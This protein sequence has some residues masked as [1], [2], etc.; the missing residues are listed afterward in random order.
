MKNSTRTLLIVLPL[1]AVLIVVLIIFTVKTA[2]KVENKLDVL[3]EKLERKLESE[4]EEDFD[5][6]DFEDINRGKPVY[7]NRDVVEKQRNIL[8]FDKIVL[9]GAYEVYL[10]KSDSVGL[11]VKTDENLQ[12]YIV[13]ESEG[14]ILEITTIKDIKKAEEIKLILYYSTLKKIDVRGAARIMNKGFIES[15]HLE[16]SVKGAASLKLN[17]KAEKL[18][19]EMAG[20]SHANIG[21]ECKSADIFIGGVGV[22]SAYDLKSKDMKVHVAGAGS[23]KVWAEKR[24][25]ASISGAGSIK[26]K[27]NPEVTEQ[28]AGF[29]KIHKIN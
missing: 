22:L 29:G 8:D 20:G 17:I 26:Y 3:G 2:K 25:D 1:A 12:E 15:E 11:I 18:D 10:K 14:N 7:G 4:M 16:V 24:L 21:G 28:I 6:G 19:V 23:A 5:G 27:G 13:A 9:K